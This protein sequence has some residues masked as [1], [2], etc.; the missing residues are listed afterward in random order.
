MARSRNVEVFHGATCTNVI[1][2]ADGAQVVGIA[3]RTA[4]NRSYKIF[5]PTVVLACGGLETPRLLLA[6]RGNRS[7]GLGNEH[8]LVGR[9]YMTHLVSDARNVGVLRFTTLKTAHAF[10]Y[11]KTPDGG[12]TGAV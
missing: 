11:V 9:F 1:T 6:S 4:S 8:D 3:L 12:C 5:A 7:C 2:N 10:D